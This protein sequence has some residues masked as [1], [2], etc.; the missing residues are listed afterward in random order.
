[1][2]KPLKVKKNI[3]LTMPK[4]ITDYVPNLLSER[5]RRQ[6]FWVWGVSLAVALIWVLAIISAP[7]FEA[8]GIKSVSQPIYGFFSYMC[9]QISARSFH[10]HEH[11][12]A[13]C[14]RCF[15]FYAG[16]LLGFVVYPFVR[17]INNTDSFPRFW[18]FAAMIPMGIDVGLDFLDI[19]NNTHLSRT[20]TGLI[21][22]FACA[23]FIIPALVEISFFARQSLKKK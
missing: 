8:E 13:V 23:F 6:A 1:L 7:I 11:Q 2:Q 17:A 16:F 22:G 14:A 19:W 18:L 9:H 10:Y 20:A 3:Y 12:F 4:P 15:G 5:L 21:L